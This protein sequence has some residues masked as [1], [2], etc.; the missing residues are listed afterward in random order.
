MKV[1]CFVLNGK[2]VWTTFS[3]ERRMYQKKRKKESFLLI[4]SLPCWPM[5]TWNLGNQK[6]LQQHV[7]EIRKAGS[8]KL[9]ILVDRYNTYCDL[10]VGAK[11]EFFFTY[12]SG[13]GV[14]SDVGSGF[15]STQPGPATLLHDKA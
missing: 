10:Y 1:N 7:A 15:G 6:R 2:Y 13:S 11:S 12:G 14:L 8:I 9:N 5:K 4:H 3:D